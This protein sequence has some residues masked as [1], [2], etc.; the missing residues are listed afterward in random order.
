MR[1]NIYLSGVVLLALQGRAVGAAD[2]LVPVLGPGVH[3][4]TFGRSPGPSIG[5]AISIP[6]G[7][8]RS[9]RVPLVIALHFGVQGG[10]SLGA[11]R[12]LLELLIAPGLAGL[13][14]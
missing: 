10:P 14:A 1:R 3:T 5:Y 11:G 12:D 9:T 8:S 6:P 2:G 7:Y 4:S 13:G